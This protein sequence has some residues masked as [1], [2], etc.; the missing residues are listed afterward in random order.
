MNAVERLTAPLHSTIEILKERAEQH[1]DHVKL[2]RRIAALWSAYLG[3]EIDPHQVPACMIL[4]KVARSESN[5]QLDDNIL[6]MAG[7]TSIYGDLLKIDRLQRPSAHETTLFDTQGPE[8]SEAH[9][10]F[11]EAD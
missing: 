2:H 9:Q 7:N 1:G 10:R 6:D 4:Y 8:D 3:I 5:P 11:S